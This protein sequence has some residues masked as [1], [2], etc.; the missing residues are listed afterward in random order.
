MWG[1]GPYWPGPIVG[2]GGFSLRSRKL[3]E[4]LRN[5][6]LTWH[7]PDLLSD[8]E[9]ALRPYYDDSSPRW[10]RCVPE[11]FVICLWYRD[12]LERDFGIRFCPP[13]LAAKFSVESATAFAQYWLGRSFGFHGAWN[14][15]YYELTYKGL[16]LTSYG[17]SRLHYGSIRIKIRKLTYAQIWLLNSQMM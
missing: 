1:G 4:A 12:R 10:G 17:V 14:A 3:Y 9:K 13:E 15:S 6:D 2:N 7:L 8:N 11:D 16:T 5:F